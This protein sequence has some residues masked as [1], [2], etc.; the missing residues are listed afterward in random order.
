MKISKALAAL[1]IG[2]VVLSGGT[3]QAETLNEAVQHVLK[4]NPNLAAMAYKRK[5]IDQEVNQ[6]KSGYLPKID[7]SYAVGVDK[8]YEPTNESFSVKQSTLSLRQNV[9]NG[10]ITDSEVKRHTAR[11]NSE[12]YRLQGNSEQTALTVANVYLNVLRH[13]EL[14]KLSQKNLE[15]HERI[16]DQIKLRSESGVD[17]KANLDQVNGRRALAKS[18]V[19]ITEINVE[20]AKTNY[21]SVIGRLPEGLSRP[22]ALSTHLPASMEEAQNKAVEKHPI[23]KSAKADLEATKAQDATAKGA[24]YPVVDLEVDKHWDTNTDNSPGYQEDMQA[25]LRVRFNLFSGWKDKSRKAET[26]ELMNE[27]TA[28]KNNTHRDVVESIRLSWMSHDAAQR[29]VTL[30]S[31]YVESA[32]ATAEAYTKQW[33]L[34]KRTMLDVLDTEAEVINAKQDLINAQYDALYAQYRILSGMGSMVHTLKMEWPVETETVAMP[35]PYTATSIEYPYLSAKATRLEAIEAA[36][37]VGVDTTFSWKT[38]DGSVTATHPAVRPGEIEQLQ[39]EG[40]EAESVIKEESSMAAKKVEVK[41]TTAAVK[42]KDSVM[43]L[44]SNATRQQAIDA[45]KAA[46]IDVTKSWKTVSPSGAMSV[47]SA[48]KN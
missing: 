39:K 16:Y 48:V 15:I 26:A 35:A 45:A 47:H 3:S 18:N 37:K 10:F 33:N 1:M 44:P 7:F 30:L 29:K 42:E 5:A 32:S 20:D 8:N 13:N 4:T 46:G 24:Y 11:V 19:V 21:Q 6:A 23:L 41:E 9:F 43:V 36:K 38:T 2:G 40:L 17:Q 27:A 31:E 14:S 28:I 12:A 22:A 34:G 25:M